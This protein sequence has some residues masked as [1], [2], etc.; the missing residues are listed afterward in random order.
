MKGLDSTNQAGKI[1]EKF[2]KSMKEVP[3]RNPGASFML[4]ACSFFSETAF[5]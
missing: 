2:Y 3:A 4:V 5:I 1:H